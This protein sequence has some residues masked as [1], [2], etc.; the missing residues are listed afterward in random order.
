MTFRPANIEL[1]RNRNYRRKPRN[2]ALTLIVPRLETGTAWV[3][4]PAGWRSVTPVRVNV[5]CSPNRTVRLFSRSGRNRLNRREKTISIFD[6]RFRLSHLPQGQCSAPVESVTNRH[7]PRSGAICC[8]VYF[9]GSP[10][11]FGNQRCALSG[12]LKNPAVTEP[13]SELLTGPQRLTPLETANVRQ[14]VQPECPLRS[15]ANLP[16]CGHTN[17]GSLNRQSGESETINRSDLGNALTVTA[18]GRSPKTTRHASN[19]G[20]VCT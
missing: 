8:G 15:E 6:F 19:M 1:A 17:P 10:V 12:T 20:A 18:P 16:P 14:P 3:R 4:L 13:A 9:A 2:V 7:R 11:F 5:S